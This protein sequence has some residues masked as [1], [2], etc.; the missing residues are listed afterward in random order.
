VAVGVGVSVG[1]GLGVTLGVK[2]GAAEGAAV[3]VG[4][5]PATAAVV[6]T[7]EAART[8]AKIDVVRIGDV[9]ED[10]TLFD[11]WSFKYRLRR[12]G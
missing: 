12:S 9:A 5:V 2:V 7:Q 11:L 3:G 6:S 1:V 4:V 8:S 10:R